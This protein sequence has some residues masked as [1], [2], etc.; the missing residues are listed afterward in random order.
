M[1]AVLAVRAH[2]KRQR[3]RTGAGVFLRQGPAPGRLHALRAADFFFWFWRKLVLF[4]CTGVVF[5]A[6]SFYLSIAYERYRTE[7]EDQNGN[8]RVHGVAHNAYT[9]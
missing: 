1:A 2:R 8:S 5:I 9:E 6:K 7:R 4:F 3:F